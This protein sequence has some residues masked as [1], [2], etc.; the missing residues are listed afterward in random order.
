MITNEQMVEFLDSNDYYGLDE[1]VGL[2][3]DLANG[4]YDIEDFK[5]DVEEFAEYE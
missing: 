5:S 3:L 1:M 4:I 2:L